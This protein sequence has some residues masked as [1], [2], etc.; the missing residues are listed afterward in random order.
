MD[1]ETT[2]EFEALAEAQERAIQTGHT[3]WAAVIGVLGVACLGLLVFLA[4]SIPWVISLVVL[5]LA[6]GGLAFLAD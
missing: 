2:G 3:A 4:L 5:A 6:I 1:G